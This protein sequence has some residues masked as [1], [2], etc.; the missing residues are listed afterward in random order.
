MATADDIDP[1]SCFG[2]SDSD[3][4][5][6]DP[7]LWLGQKMVEVANRKMAQNETSDDQTQQQAPAVNVVNGQPNRDMDENTLAD[8][9]IV[10]ISD[11]LVLWPDNP[12]LF[13]GQIQLVSSLPV[14]GGRGFAAT[15]ALAPGTLIM[16]EEAMTTWSDAQLGKTLEL[17]SVKYILDHPD[18][19]KFSQDLEDFHPTKQ[20]VD[21]SLVA[22]HK[23]TT[24]SGKTIQI[25]EMMKMLQEQNNGDSQVEDLID[26][27]LSRNITC[28][29]GTTLTRTDIIR[30]LLALRYNG[31]ETGIYRHVAMLN[32][33]CYP[34][35]TKYKPE[36]GKKYT[37][38]RTT[39]PVAAGENLTIS[40]L[41]RLL[42]HASR[43]RHLWDQ[44]RFDIGGAETLVE[45]KKRMESVKGGKLPL[46]SIH[47]VNESDVTFRIE[48]AIGEL[49]ELYQDT[50]GAIRLD[51]SS[52]EKEDPVWTHLYALELAS[53]ELYD[54]AK[55]QLGNDSH[56]LLL[57]CLRLHLNAAE[58]VQ[59]D[60]SLTT[61]SQRIKL[62]CRLVSSARSLVALQVD[63]YGPDHFDV[64]QT[65][66]ELA[67]A[68][69]EL[70]SRAPKQLLQLE[71]E[72]MATF[73]ACSTIEY[74][75][76]KDSERIQALYPRDAEQFIK[77]G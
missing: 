35:C 66:L 54:E 6:E 47:H 69:E 56:L 31:L 1:F 34:N 50:I 72:G 21:D 17:V 40:Y 44:H 13:L 10:K 57:A 29:N 46:S 64:A 14:G 76:R 59:R 18:G 71:L 43:R 12:P 36:P 4:E 16:L 11:Y 19:N 51:P 42:S 33:D 62:L 52:I 26:L 3:D 77:L 48:S 63:L 65:N 55:K 37:E 28:R 73:E 2:D 39:R 67:Q 32:H 49:E 27:S 75:S 38:V 45:G 25:H 9:G 61:G 58:L 5:E 41:P 20:D 8:T 30:M 68:L 70:L 7:P 24:N 22:N 74:A 60:P 53:V 15:R 23:T